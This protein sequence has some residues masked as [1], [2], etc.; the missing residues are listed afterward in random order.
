[1][2]NRKELKAR[3]KAAFKR[4][5]WYCVLAA[6]LLTLMMAALAG[7]GNPGVDVNS[8]SG[9]HVQIAFGSVALITLIRILALN[10]F[11]VSIR[12]FF[13]DN[14]AGAAPLDDFVAGFTGNYVRNVLA[15]FLRTLLVAL[16][17]L[18]LVIPGIV[19][20]YSY[21][22]VPYILADNPDIGAKEAIDLSRNMMKGNKWKAFVLD[23]SF[24]GWYLLS[25][26]TFGLLTVFYVNPYV[27]AADA[28][29]YRT[30]RDNR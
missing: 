21:K 8:S 9:V 27:N 26:L 22:L 29:L 13:A 20:A 17:S 4:N 2:W 16:W 14:A 11:E 10:P 6:L 28:E 7:S 25:V 12:K 23:L 5:Y 18:L 15:M 24:I 19:K 30:L 3:A 1:M